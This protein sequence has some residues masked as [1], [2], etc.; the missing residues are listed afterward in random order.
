MARAN[1]TDHI[2]LM[3][4]ASDGRLSRRALL[5]RARAIG[6]GGAATAVLL[7]MPGRAGA[8]KSRVVMT[9][10]PEPTACFNGCDTARDD[11]RNTPGQ[12]TTVCDANHL[13]CRLGCI[14][15]PAPGPLL[16][17]RTS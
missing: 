8:A 4:S 1:S 11:C 12:D 3:R 7:A 5:R 6:L 14:N 16:L 17:R 9:P 10:L 2:E 15:G 13:T